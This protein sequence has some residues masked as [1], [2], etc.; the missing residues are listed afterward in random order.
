MGIAKVGESIEDTEN[1]EVSVILAFLS[2]SDG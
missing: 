1:S 2:P